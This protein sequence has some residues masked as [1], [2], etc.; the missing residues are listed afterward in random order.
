MKKFFI[1]ITFFILTSTD[2]FAANAAQQQ[3]DSRLAETMDRVVT[4]GGGG[5]GTV[6]NTTVGSTT[7]STTSN[8]INL[9][10]K[11]TCPA[12]MY[13]S[14][15]CC[16]FTKKKTE[17]CPAG[18]TAGL[19]CSSGYDTQQ[20]GTAN[21]LPCV[22]C[23]AQVAKCLYNNNQPCPTGYF[24]SGIAKQCC[25]NGSEPVA[26]RCNPLTAIEKDPIPVDCSCE[27]GFSDMTG[28]SCPAGQTKMP[29]RSCVDGP[30][31]A[32]CV[33]KTS[34]GGGGGGGGGSGNLKYFQ[35]SRNF[36]PML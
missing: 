24:C 25:P 18:Y 2:A 35:N 32:K 19:V 23:V 17:S 30:Q 10:N 11:I 9:C 22:K 15:G 4:G 36:E 8:N 29:G 6:T 3:V 16:S 1:L 21:G 27:S 7:S 5:G 20:S 31:C 33:P 13:C 34:S 12:G 28:K 26:G 14:D